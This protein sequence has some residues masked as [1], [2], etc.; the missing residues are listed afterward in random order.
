MT[1]AKLRLA[2][3]QVIA[4]ALLGVAWLQGLVSEAIEAD[5]THIIVWLIAAVALVMSL[6]TWWQRGRSWT[7]WTCEWAI[8]AMLGFLGTTL[9]LMQALEGLV[10][11]VDAQKLAG[12]ETALVTTAVGITATLYLLLIERVSR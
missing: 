6:A 10:G 5:R 11:D 1:Q 8:P 4:C 12:V 7:A 3:V 2:V 9:G